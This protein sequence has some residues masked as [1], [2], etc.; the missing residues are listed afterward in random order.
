M[1]EVVLGYRQSDNQA[2]SGIPRSAVAEDDDAITSY[3]IT[4]Q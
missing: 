3:I 2:P 4:S 1:Q